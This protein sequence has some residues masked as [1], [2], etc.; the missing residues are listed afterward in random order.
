MINDSI[1]PLKEKLEELQDLKRILNTLWPTYVGKECSDTALPLEAYARREYKL[2]T[3]IKT[4]I[5]ASA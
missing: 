4:L 1:E 3:E 2:E 5:Q